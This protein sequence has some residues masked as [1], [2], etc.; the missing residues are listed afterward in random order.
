MI[1]IRMEQVGLHVSAAY[2]KPEK[3]EVLKALQRPLK[4]TQALAR[5]I[6]QRVQREGK[7]V[8]DIDSDAQKVTPYDETK[9]GYVVNADYMH[10]T[11]LGDKRGRFVS[12]ADFHRKA[13]ARAGHYDTGRGSGMWSGMYVR[14]WGGKGAIID[15]R[16]RSLGRKVHYTKS[17]DDIAKAKTERLEMLR[18]KKTKRGKLTAATKRKIAEVTSGE[19]E[20]RF[21]KIKLIPNRL[22]AATIFQAH[23]VNVIVPSRTEIQTMMHAFSYRGQQTIAELLGVNPA[24]I[25]SD[26]QRNK[27]LFGA[28]VRAMK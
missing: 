17:R 15:F 25:R 11:G 5:S 14:N 7:P 18:N 16:R 1:T 21:A 28:A 24:S 13:N 12:S 27:K 6:K 10:K 23:S 8:R 26:A 3:A 20:K 9:R 22:K 2:K 19:W 4:L